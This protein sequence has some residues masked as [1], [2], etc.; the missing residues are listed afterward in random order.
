M[1]AGEVEHDSRIRRR[2]ERGHDEGELGGRLFGT[3]LLDLDA[4]IAEQSGQGA[5]DDRRL[6]ANGHSAS[7]LA[8]VVDQEGRMSAR[9][10]IVEDHGLIAETLGA[11]LGARNLVV[12][13]VHATSA[14]DVV[15]DVRRASPD[16]ILLDLDLG[17]ADRDGADLVPQLAPTGAAVVMLT[18]VT[19]EIRL[20][21]CIRAGA[22]GVLSK[23]AGFDRLV[24][25]VRQVVE[26]G[27]LLSSHERE[28]HLALLRRHER[29]VDRRLHRFRELTPREAE[30]LRALCHGV[31]VDQIAA[32]DQVSVS[33]V[34]TQVRAIRR[35]LGVSSQL[36]ATALARD[37]GWLDAT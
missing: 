22:V 25:A 33:T 4:P 15:T 1:F 6:D 36:A 19:D 11:A 10:V 21:R 20:A 35:K 12:H 3:D 13:V 30:I 37:S 18:G 23:S 5:A 31:T 29:D 32:G 17:D 34:R 28:E 14:T 26:R 2:I 24:A 9:V 27:T 8:L 7:C 16:V